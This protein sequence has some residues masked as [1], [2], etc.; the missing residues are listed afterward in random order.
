MIESRVSEQLDHLRQSWGW[1]L[2]LGILLVL[3]GAAA[4]S[5]PFAATVGFVTLLGILLLAA[6]VA[7]I[8]SAFHCHGWQGVTVCLVVGVLYLVMGFLVLENPID[9]AAGLT[10]LLAALFLMGGIIRI[11][12]AMRDRFPG[13]GWVLLS[14]AVS[15]LLGLI[16]WRQFPASALTV[17][18]LLIGI[19]FIF[20]GWMWIMLSFAFKQFPRRPS[21]PA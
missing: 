1:I 4:I 19:E 5:L 11:V 10:L 15:A 14:G 2:A 6:G 18:G 17:I 8:V 12:I 20:N 9:G 16:I 13:W 3:A 7:Q 21:G